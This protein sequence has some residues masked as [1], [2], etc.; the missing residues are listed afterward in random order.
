MKMCDGKLPLIWKNPTR[1]QWRHARELGLGMGWDP[2]RPTGIKRPRLSCPKCGRRLWA[3]VSQNDGDLLFGL[4]P[5][6]PKGWA[7][8]KKHGKK[9]G[10]KHK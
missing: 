9:W 6:K 7:H 4:P 3:S 8:G 2:E 1:Y 10:K 5:H